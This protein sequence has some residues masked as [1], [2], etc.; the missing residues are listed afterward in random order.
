MKTTKILALILSMLL[1]HLPVSTFASSDLS[2]AETIS[3]INSVF[4]DDNAYLVVRAGTLEDPGS[5]DQTEY[6][7]YSID[8]TTTG[9][10]KIFHTSERYSSERGTD[11][12][13]KEIDDSD[14]KD[15]D[16]DDLCT[17][18]YIKT[19]EGESDCRYIPPVHRHLLNKKVIAVRLPDGDYVYLAPCGHHPERMLK[20]F[21]HLLART[22]IECADPF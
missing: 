17:I 18:P 1:A 2:L 14:W 12:R 10:L 6:T 4:K 20:A 13:P 16:E 22:K 21:R 8:I 15:L 7:K 9:M 5:S 3:W 11:E 19:T